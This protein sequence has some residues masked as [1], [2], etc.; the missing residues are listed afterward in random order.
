MMKK[1]FLLIVTS[2]WLFG[3]SF[4]DKDL[5]NLSK[6]QKIVLNMAK[7]IGEMKG[8][9]NTLVKIAAVETRFDD[10]KAN[11]GKYCGPMQI[12]I[13]YHGVSCAAVSDNLYLSMEL[14]ANEMKNWLDIHNQDMDKAYLAYNAGYMKNTHGPEYLRR[15][16]MVGAVLKKAGI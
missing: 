12:A 4:T 1:I 14:A 7:K 13:K 10:V 9:G 2:G 15:I 3:W 6:Q 16:H 8:L 5:A 11:N